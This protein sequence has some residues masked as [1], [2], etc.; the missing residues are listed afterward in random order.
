AVPQPSE[1]ADFHQALDVHGNLLAEIAFH[2]ALVLD[3]PADLPDVVF[4]QILDADV[5]AD[6]GALQ[7]VV[8]AHTPYAVDVSETDLDALGP[9]EI[10][11]SNTCHMSVL[12]PSFLVPSSPWQKSGCIR[13][14]DFHH[15]RPSPS[16]V[17][18]PRSS[19]RRWF[20]AR[21]R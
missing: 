14:R 19:G 3:H 7:D 8:R 5:G 6:P 12:R 13:G 10:H 16:S 15:G 2:A 9:R 4:G 17:P 21:A 18:G 20:R 1:A 11:A